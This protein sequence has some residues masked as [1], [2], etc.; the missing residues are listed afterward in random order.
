M[1]REPYIS[2]RTD[3]ASLGV[4]RAARQRYDAKKGKFVHLALDRTRRPWVGFLEAPTDQDEPQIISDGAGTTG[5]VFNSTLFARHLMNLLDEEPDETVRFHFAGEET[6]DPE[7]GATL[8][9]LE[10]PEV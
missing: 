6:T 5:R 2:V 10:V 9:R 1:G 8:Y 4:S 3:R 7:T